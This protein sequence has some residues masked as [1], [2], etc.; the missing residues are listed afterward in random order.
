M[1]LFIRAAEIDGSAYIADFFDGNAFIQQTGNTQQNIFSHAVGQQIGARIHQN[2]TAHRIRPIIVMGK[3]AQGCLQASDDDGN[4]AVC[5]PNT[6]AIDDGSAVGTHASLTAGGVV[7]VGS[8][9]LGGGIVR[10]HGI[11]ITCRNQKAK[12]RLSK[13]AESGAAFIIGL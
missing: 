1:K 4:I 9:F 5:F 3:A 11:N 7:V 10:H 12:A 6:V 2:R 13:L 8:F